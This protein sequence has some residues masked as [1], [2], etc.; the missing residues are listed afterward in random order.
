M[1]RRY[2]LISPCRD[3][4]AYIQTTI[5]SITSQSLLPTKWLIVDDGST[6]G[7][8]DIIAAAAS[9]Y[10]FIEV[11]KRGD[12]GKRSV[13]PGVIE[14]FYAGYAAI[15]PTDYDYVCKLDVDL[16]IP[17]TYFKRMV[18]QMEAT[19]RLGTCSGKPYFPGKDGEL[20]SERCGDENSVGM[21]KFYRRECFEEIGGFVRQ[22]MWDGI[23]GHRCRMLGWIACS[24]DEP[25]LRFIHLRPMGSSQKN[26]FT[27]RTRHGAGQYFM[28]TGLVYMAASTVYRMVTPPYV[29]G[30]AMM[31]YGYLKSMATQ[32]ERYGD[33][34]FRKFL[35]DYQ[36]RCLVEG[37]QKATEALNQK[38][39]HVWEK[40]HA[41]ANHASKGQLASQITSA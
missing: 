21:I 7:T 8:Q 22:V 9:E 14:A 31:M 29:V 38:Q 12:R 28:G 32:K 41:Q 17:P 30:G 1:A 18:E 33:S 25:D 6:D 10:A 37:K 23:D 2:V 15:A 4:V 5:D 11:V 3:E 27:G 36:R 20:V 34:A 35:R 26:I 16:D 19:P 13:G 39:A 40:G 24:W